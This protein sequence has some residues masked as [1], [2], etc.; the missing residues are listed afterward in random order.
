MV[1]RQ[2]LERLQGLVLYLCVALMLL[3]RPALPWMLLPF[4]DTELWGSGMGK[5]FREGTWVKRLKDRGKK[6]F[7]KM[8]FFGCFFCQLPFNLK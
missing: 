6:S 5:W 8:F 4:A 2:D 1:L 3:L 7:L